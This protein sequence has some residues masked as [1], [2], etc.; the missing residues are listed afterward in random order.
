MKKG[1][2]LGNEVRDVVTGFQGIVI[3]HIGYLSGMAQMQVQP[4]VE[5]HKNGKLPNAE[6]LYESRLKKIGEGFEHKPV[7]EDFEIG[8]VGDKPENISVPESD[9]PVVD[10]PGKAAAGEGGDGEEGNRDVMQ[11]IGG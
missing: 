8:K 11:E 2:E 1:I 5:E 4:S 7:V 6:W 9:G 3:A 10:E